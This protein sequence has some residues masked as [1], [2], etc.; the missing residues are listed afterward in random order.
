MQEILDAQDSKL[1]V[2][3]L[4][5]DRSRDGGS[6]LWVVGELDR[7]GTRAL[8][9]LRVREDPG[10]SKSCRGHQRR[11]NRR[12][13]FDRDIDIEGG[14]WLVLMDLH[15]DAADDRVRDAR[16]RHKARER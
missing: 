14:A 11:R 12:S 4:D 13:V 3:E 16:L 8:P 2:L 5:L 15:R 10:S 1:D 7:S 6:E 9:V